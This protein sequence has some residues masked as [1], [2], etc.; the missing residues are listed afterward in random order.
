M[1]HLIALL[2][3]LRSI[4]EAAV[5]IENIG[6]IQK[7]C[8]LAKAAT[9]ESWALKLTYKQIAPRLK[10]AFPG[11]SDVFAVLAK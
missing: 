11:R 3:G 4:R 8:K 10:N 6:I 5:P 7:A 9:L 1:R 2:N